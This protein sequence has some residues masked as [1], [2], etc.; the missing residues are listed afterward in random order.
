MQPPILVAGLDGRSLPLEVPVLQRGG[1]LVH[2]HASARALV[3]ALAGGEGRLVVLGTQL[4]DL[5]V[6][7]TIQRIRSNTT[8]R[9]ASVLVLLPAAE[10][11]GMEGRVLE[12]GANVVLRRPLDPSSLDASFAKLLAVPRRIEARVPVRGHVV[13]TPKTAGAAHFCGLT[14]NISVNGMLL[15]SPMPLASGPDMELE[16]IL[17]NLTSRLAA[18]GR[19][20]REASEVAWPYVGYGVEFLFVPPDSLD[21]IADLVVKAAFPLPVADRLGAIHSTLK[22]DQWIYEIR[23]PVRQPGGW[24]VEIR[25]AP[26]ENWRPGSSGPFYVV[27]GG[28]AREALDAARDFLHRHS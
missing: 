14:R 17:P 8:T 10:P 4:S 22:R 16:L 5:N 24:H 21:A 2:E 18:L 6:F 1:H 7:E 25:R 23:Q 9:H 26:R 19:V 3:D 13:G 27:E 28:S 11:P 20:V 12:A 15:A